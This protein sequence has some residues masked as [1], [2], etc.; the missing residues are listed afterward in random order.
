MR[1]LSLVAVVAV[2]ACAA[3]GSSSHAVDPK[4]LPQLVLQPADLPSWTRFENDAGTAADA[5]VLGSHNR[6]GAWI[7]RYRSPSGVVVSRVDLYRSSS[8]AKD[9]FSQLRS[10]ASSG[11]AVRSVPT[12]PVGDER[13]GYLTG[14]LQMLRTIFWRRANAIGSIVVQGRDVSKPDAGALSEKVDAR[15]KAA[16]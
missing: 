9:V 11:S 16:G 13:V 2:V 3:C 10:E 14:T 5:G 12:P 6:T 15:M 8:D 1:K 7:A 4:S